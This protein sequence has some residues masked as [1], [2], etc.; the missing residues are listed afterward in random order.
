ME[1]KTFSTHFSKHCSFQQGS[2]PRA[3]LDPIKKS[4][5]WRVYCLLKAIQLLVYTSSQWYS[6]MCCI[7]RPA[8]AFLH[9]LKDFVF[10]CGNFK[11]YQVLNHVEMLTSGKSIIVIIALVTLQVLFI[12][13][14][15]VPTWE[16]SCQRRFLHDIFSFL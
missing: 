13:L 7:S 16:S 15:L 4:I 10:Q 11:S 5:R 2:I 14:S 6:C 8:L 9:R 1:I 12:F 3:D